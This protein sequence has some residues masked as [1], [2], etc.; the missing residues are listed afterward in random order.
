MAAAYSA[1][2]SVTSPCPTK[3]IPAQAVA[4]SSANA[5]SSRFLAAEWS[6]SA[7]STG[8]MST[9]SAIASVLAYASCCAPR[10]GASPALATRT[11]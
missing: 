8:D 2:A 7:P 3:N 1:D 4:P 6:A 10:P 5:A 9:T 11:K